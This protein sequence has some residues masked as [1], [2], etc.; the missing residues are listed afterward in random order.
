VEASVEAIYV[1]V[2][3]EKESLFHLQV[4]VQAN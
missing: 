2:L 4:S 1:G 3:G